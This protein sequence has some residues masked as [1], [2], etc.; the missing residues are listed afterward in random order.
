MIL[1]D[2]GH[3]LKFTSTRLQLVIHF[4]LGF[5]LIESGMCSMKNEV[6]ILMKNVIDVVLGGLLF[7]EEIYC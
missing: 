7:W 4:S 6:N 3:K 2:Y 1:W 5:G